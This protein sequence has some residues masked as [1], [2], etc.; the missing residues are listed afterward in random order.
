LRKQAADRR[1]APLASSSQ[2]GGNIGLL[3][4]SQSASGSAKRLEDCEA[5]SILDAT[6]A[7]AA[8][9]GGAA[10]GAKDNL[11]KLSVMC[12]SGASRHI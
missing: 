9:G 10:A 3:T 4:D 6:V 7:Y 5:G 2:E 8:A 11:H 1:N 12:C